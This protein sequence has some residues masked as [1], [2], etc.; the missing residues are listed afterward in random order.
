L[1]NSKTVLRNDAITGADTAAKAAGTEIY[2]AAE[3]L[4]L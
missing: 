1:V 4:L 3:S 2:P